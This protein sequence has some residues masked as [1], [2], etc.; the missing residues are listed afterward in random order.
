MIKVSRLLSSIWSVSSFRF[1]YRLFLNVAD[2]FCLSIIFAW[3][4]G[5]GQEFVGISTHPGVVASRG[6]K[7]IASGSRVR[8]M[9][10]SVGSY[11]SCVPFVE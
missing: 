10:L 9:S 8:V 11:F 7:L 1:V 3:E 5:G 4:R 2:Q 6:D